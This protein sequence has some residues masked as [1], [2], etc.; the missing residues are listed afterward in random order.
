MMGHNYDID[1]EEEF[2][3]ADRYLKL[4]SGNQKFVFDID[5]VI[6]EYRENLDYASAS[7]DYGIISSINQ[8]YE[9]GNYIVLF[10]ARGTKT[11][12]DWKEVTKK[13]ME[14]WGVKYHELKFGKPDADF[15]VDDKMVGLE[16]IME[17]FHGR[18]VN[19]DK[20]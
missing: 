15:Y 13:Q 12:I 16:E 20:D 10:T 9:A 7:P 4:M 5:G 8:L 3:K 2:R 18:H 19:M 11:G 14:E 1:T 17:L 6:A